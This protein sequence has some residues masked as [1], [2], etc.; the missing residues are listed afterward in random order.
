MTDLASL[1]AKTP[2]IPR[3]ED[4][5]GGVAHAELSIPN[6]ILLFARRT[7]QLLG[8]LRKAFDHH[9]RFVLI[10]NLRTT[11]AVGID[12]QIVRLEQGQSV[13]VFPHQFHHYL[14][15]EG[16]ILN[17]L[18]VTFEMEDPA[19]LEPLKNIRL[20]L[21]AKALGLLRNLVDVTLAKDFRQK[22]VNNQLALWLALILEELLSSAKATTAPRRKTVSETQAEVL[23][24]R[25]HRYLLGHINENFTL[26]QLARSL[27]MSESYLRSLFRRHFG[28]SIGH[29]VRESRLAK[30]SGLIHNSDL[31]FS[32]IAEECG[33][34]SVYSFS[35]AFK[36][37]NGLS[38]REYRRFVR[39][40]FADRVKQARDQE[41]LL[42][43]M[44]APS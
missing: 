36:R 34:D 16:D 20:D 6:Y 4:Y 27:R 21:S 24:E 28:V 10:F 30:A 19:G 33:F 8:T 35:R 12:R 1:C 15:L 39:S 40:S 5:Y 26:G 43:A 23:V 9:H 42:P 7:P 3:V 41:K 11:G 37:A 31:N 38:P 17:W 25:V 32:Q 44:P 18:F 13:L 2:E 22:G 14:N 29:Y